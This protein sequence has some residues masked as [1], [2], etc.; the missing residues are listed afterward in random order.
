[1]P[2]RRSLAAR[3]T[4]RS[5][6]P[7]VRLMAIYRTSQSPGLRNLHY[8]P[9]CKLLDIA[10]RRYRLP[11]VASLPE[12]SAIDHREPIVSP[13]ISP[14]NPTYR[15]NAA[16]IGGVA[17]FLTPSLALFRSNFSFTHIP[18]SVIRLVRLY[19]FSFFHVSPVSTGQ[20][21]ERILFSRTAVIFIG[22]PRRLYERAPFSGMEIGCR[23]SDKLFESHSTAASIII[24]VDRK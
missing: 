23:K 1:M 16:A 4:L 8:V 6:T 18:S 21:I 20:L 24:T 3:R 14:R 19:G 11:R 2:F 10:I 7:F 12:I 13:F 22:T 5:P 17:A 15:V 9:P